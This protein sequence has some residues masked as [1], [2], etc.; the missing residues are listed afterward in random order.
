MLNKYAISLLLLSFVLLTSCKDESD[1]TPTAQ[2]QNF[3]LILDTYK[4]GGDRQF[5]GGFL[6]GEEGAIT[7][8]PIDNTFQVKN[9]SFLFGGTGNT[10]V[11][12]DVTLKIY[13]DNGAIEPGDMVF[14]KRYTINSSN[15]VFQEIDLS[16]QNVTI[17]GGGKI[18]VSLEMSAASFPSIARDDG[19]VFQV[20]R[21]WVKDV[22]NTWKTSEMFGMTGNWIIRASIEGTL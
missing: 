16:N 8:G 7:L 12:R 20:N 14:S 4:S 2:T 17:V 21:N 15:D 13:K 9:V 1:D 6:A 5:Q 3:E 18:R 19:G 11:E 10:S 22:D